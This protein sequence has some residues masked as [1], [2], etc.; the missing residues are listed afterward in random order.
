VAS[1]SHVLTYG[2][3]LLVSDRPF[4]RDCLTQN[5]VVFVDPESGPPSAGA[6]RPLLASEPRRRALGAA[7]LARSRAFSFRDRVR[8]FRDFVFGAPARADRCA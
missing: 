4:D 5:E 8:G 1:V 6:I 3:P 7:A 2:V